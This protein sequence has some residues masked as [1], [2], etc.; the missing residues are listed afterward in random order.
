MKE[1][2]S[3]V[4]Q[5]IAERVRALRSGQGLSLDALAAKSGVSRSMISVIERG[6]TSP[7]AVLLEKLAAGLGVTM[8]SLFETSNPAHSANSPVSRRED[9]AQ[10]KDPGSGYVR[11]NVSPTSI[12]QPMQ[13]VEVDFPPGARVAF[14]TGTRDQRIHQQIWILEG[15][16]EITAGND[17]H[18]LAKGDCLACQLDRPMSFHNPTRKHA[19]YAVI[20][21]SEP[22]SRR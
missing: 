18:T 6:L 11:R 12:R 17:R 22:A 7:T 9:Q 21:V 16:M 3:D 13:I 4:N 10:W 14:E 1:P 20:I 19:R 2:P 8:A 5:R 15:A